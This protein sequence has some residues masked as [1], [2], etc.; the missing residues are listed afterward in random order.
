MQVEMKSGQ[1]ISAW[2][3]WDGG[4]ARNYMDDTYL[5]SVIRCTGIGMTESQVI[6]GRATNLSPVVITA[7][8]GEDFDERDKFVK[9]VAV[10]LLPSAYEE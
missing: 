7:E 1:T 4:S 10:A 9:V 6:M 2:I 5:F 8:D 3:P